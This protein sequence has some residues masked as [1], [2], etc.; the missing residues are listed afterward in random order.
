[1][2]WFLVCAP[3]STS[4]AAVAGPGQ[5]V[6]RLGRERWVHARIRACREAPSGRTQN[7][8]ALPVRRLD[9][10]VRGPAKSTIHAVLDRHGLV[11]RGGRSSDH[12][13]A[14]R[15]RACSFRKYIGS[16]RAVLGSSRTSIGC[17][18]G[19][20][21]NSPLSCRERWDCALVVV[22]LVVAELVGTEVSRAF[23]SKSLI[24]MQRVVPEQA[25]KVLSSE[26]NWM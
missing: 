22:R 1:M 3:R 17:A 8:P 18:S 19:R 23:V 2:P 21:R 20:T 14:L 25:S 16:S 11:G 5:N 12:V 4:D 10:D 13:G 24:R 15:N 9:G 7:P 26:I 6:E